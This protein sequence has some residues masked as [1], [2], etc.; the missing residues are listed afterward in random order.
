VPPKK[1]A[2]RFSKFV[3][4]RSAK[5]WIKSG[6]TECQFPFPER[7]CTQRAREGLGQAVYYRGT[8]GVW[9]RSVSPRHEV[10]APLVVG[11]VYYLSC[12]LLGDRIY[13]PYGSTDLWYRLRNGGYVSDAL[14]YTGTNYVISGVAHC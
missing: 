4:K 12:W 13:G 9:S 5:K 8:P 2:L 7:F 10:G 11:S 6:G 1:V 3:I 14:L